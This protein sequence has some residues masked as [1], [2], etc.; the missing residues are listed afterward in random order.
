[1]VRIFLLG[2]LNRNMLKDIPESRAVREF[3]TSLN[4]SQLITSPTRETERSS[5]LID[6]IMTS[7]SSLIVENGRLDAHLIDHYLVFS[8]L[9]LKT[10][11]PA[12]VYITAR[13]YKNY[14][15]NSFLKDLAKINWS[16]NTRIDDC[17]GKVEH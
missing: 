14:N 13:N 10:P 9:N 6:G 4:L 2:D 5:S 12:P 11:K 1:M 7:N 17:N 8:V 16:E 3:C 15:S